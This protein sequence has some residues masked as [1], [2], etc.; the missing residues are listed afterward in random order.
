MVGCSEEKARRLSH[1]LDCLILTHRCT[2][3]TLPTGATAIPFAVGSDN[4]KTK[5]SAADAKTGGRWPTDVR[6]TSRIVRRSH[7][8]WARKAIERSAR[9]WM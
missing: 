9:S 5:T 1:L 2:L 3:L 6:G 8:R 4:L 7:R